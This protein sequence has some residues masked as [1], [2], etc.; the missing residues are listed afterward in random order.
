M[1]DLPE[2]EPKSGTSLFTNQFSQRDNFDLYIFRYLSIYITDYSIFVS[3]MLLH[4]S[5]EVVDLSD[6][7]L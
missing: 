5:D 2:P 3:L 1:S 6:G 7:T 4:S